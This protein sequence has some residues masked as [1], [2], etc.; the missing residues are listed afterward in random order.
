MRQKVTAIVVARNGAGYLEGTLAA[1]AS[2]TRPADVIIGVDV[3][4]TD[5]TAA[6]LSAAAPAQV[7]TARGTTAFGSA[8]SAALRALPPAELDNEW[9]WL[10]SHDSA[11]EPHAL[12]RLL[13][14]V[15]IAPSVGIVGPK[16][17]HWD[18]PDTIAEFGES[19]TRFGASLA[20]VENELDQAQHDI[21]ADVLGVAAHGM[22]IRR[23]LFTTLGGFDPALPSI[24]AGLD[25]CIRARLAG[26]RVTLVPD[27]KVC[28]SGAPETF[29]KRTISPG[30]RRRISRSAQLHR[31]LSYAPALAV[32]FHW[33]MLVP[34]AI[35]R[36]IGHLLAKRPGAV[37]GEFRT[38]FAAAFR[39]K[40][41]IHARRRI[42]D[43]RTSGWGVIAPLRIPWS[44]VRER[45]GQNR[46]ARITAATVN[47]AP[48]VEFLGAAGIGVIGL[49]TLLSIIA[50]APLLS[51]TALS[52]GGLLPL[53]GSLTDMWSRIGY[54]WREIGT[55]FIG[56]ADPFTALLAL[57]GTI[58][59]WSP[60][61]SIVIVYFLAIPLA[62]T[63]AWF[64]ARRLSTRSWIPGVAA[65]LWGLAPSLLASL[66]GGH[67]GAVIAH[68]L[69]PSLILTLVGAAKSWPA[70][71]GAS[72]L[73]AAITA[74]SPILAVPL[75][76]MWL[77]WMIARP[78]GIHRTIGIPLLTAALFAPLAVQQVLRGTPL[79]LL[80]DPGSPIAAEAPGGNAL[81]VG[82]ADNTIHGWAPLLAGWPAVAPWVTTGALAVF[83]LI[84]L[85]ALIAP[86][87]PG[88]P[89]AIPAL[90]V[91]LGG[92]AL[93]AV[94]GHLQPAS[95]GVEPVSVW[96]GAPLS[97]MWLGLVGCIIVSLE[98]LGAAAAAF[99]ALTIA[100]TVVLG[101]PLIG[102]ALLGTTAIQ[103]TTGRLVPAVVAAE[104]TANPQVGTL[105]I[106]PAD[107]GKGDDAIIARVE[108]G[109]GT[110]L[111]G[112][113][114]L[115][116]T[117][118][119]PTERDIH[120]ATLA[121]NLI[122]RTGYN[123]AEEL[124]AQGI[125]FVVLAP[126]TT[127]TDSTQAT[128]RR[129]T[130]A[131]G[132]SGALS[133]VG[134]GQS[135]MLWRVAGET[136]APERPHADDVGALGTLIPAGQA[137]I[138][139]ITLLLAIPTRRAHRALRT[140]PDALSDP[141][142]TFDEEDRD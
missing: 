133:A 124:A 123:T 139:V 28:T 54:G 1:L 103:P 137:L 11:P 64:A 3:E 125:D 55:G 122:S 105:V 71:A 61:F 26:S 8:V 81:V 129:A 95:A 50:W 48:T 40:P 73:L 38:A 47:T 92:L 37:G 75:L 19:M 29:E 96:A 67:L 56:A 46:E 85:V 97:L 119:S 57:L 112:Q 31:R 126:A 52:G 76:I 51:A 39:G 21:A 77:I 7:I 35:L 5:A 117:R 58:T 128:T 91:A 4:S 87:V 14:A 33:M 131:L 82:S 113:S 32:P 45:R 2:Q 140:A 142:T 68:I 83:G 20:L 109:H 120:L 106:T 59:W 110:P 24:D 107:T 66:H 44:E 99:G 88:S 16:M 43:A 104:A 94:S 69:L 42:A 80:A 41:V 25:L 70:A 18:R 15:E 79:G 121:G 62:G 72:L 114:T 22:L 90:L 138:F 130:E 53:D 49:L 6:I 141:A 36:S 108:R 101:A 93:A 89:R 84:A 116:A 30:R 23:S 86:F 34:L 12:E 134:A 60:S 132:A 10:L 136:T 111:T 98:A 65:V 135:G 100:T 17:M 13:G 27:A 9:L 63:T 118:T 115:H 78:R 102:A 74:G 127:D